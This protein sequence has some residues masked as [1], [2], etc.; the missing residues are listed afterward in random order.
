[1][2]HRVGIYR[3]L[4]RVFLLSVILMLLGQVTGAALA[5]PNFSLPGAAVQQNQQ[6]PRFESADCMFKYASQ[7]PKSWNLQCGYLVVPETYENPTGRT[8]RLAVVIFKARGGN[9][10]ANPLFMLQ[11]GPGGST[12]DI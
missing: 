11:G 9:P 3:V 10:A 4:Q 12:I 2:A 7:I 6:V 5:T 1:M 8:I